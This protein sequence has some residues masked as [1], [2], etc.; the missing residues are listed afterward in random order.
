M[1]LLRKTKCRA[2]QQIIHAAI[3]LMPYR[4][5]VLLHSITDIIQVLRENQ[6]EQVL[7]V[8]DQGIRKAGLTAELERLLEEN[9]IGCTVYDETSVNPTITNIEQARKK[10]RD[11][12][13]QAIIAV[14]GGSAMDCAKGAAAR[15]SRPDRSLNEM[16]GLLQVNKT[17]PLLIAV[18]TTAG[19]GSETTLAAVVTDDSTHHKYAINDFNLIPDYAVLDPKLTL[20]LPPMLTATTGMDALTHAVEVYIGHSMTKQTKAASEE[21]VRLIFSN[22][23]NA[24]QD[25]KNEEARRN[26]LQASYLA[27]SAFS[28][29]Y[30]GYVHAVAH[31][32]GGK[33][34]VAHGLANAVLLPK[35]LRAYGRSVT[36]PLAR[37]A[38]QTGL[39]NTHTPKEEAA[40]CFISHIE[41]MNRRMGVPEKID[42]IRE[43]DIP[44]LAVQADKEANPLYPVPRLF[45]ANELQALYRLAM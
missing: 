29:S 1:K 3:P 10:Y 41:E 27:G 39:A 32:L 35:V 33:Y 44:S 18:P 20:G 11:S 19:T 37:L 9:G 25:G 17:T 36:V 14:G 13:C 42:G 38:I 23:E 2:F 43:E 31:S 30:V 21:A 16:E 24:Y 28:R 4:D 6:F 8:T 40:E 22:L 26:M 15:I 45:D 34:G 5:P 12:F 7:L